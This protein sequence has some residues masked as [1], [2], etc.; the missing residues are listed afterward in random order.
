MTAI[1]FSFIPDAET[2]YQMIARLMSV[3]KR[4]TGIEVILKRMEWDDAWPQLISTG[5]S[6]RT[7]ALWHRIEHQLGVE[8]GAIAAKLFQ[9][10]DADF[11]SLITETMDSLAQ[12]LN[13][14]LE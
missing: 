13:L 9:D 6:Y 7:T 10:P 14:T 4:E 5:R 8:L 2:D 3:F 1:E 12:R 11:D